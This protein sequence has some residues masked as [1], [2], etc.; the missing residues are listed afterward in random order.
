MFEYVYKNIYI[1]V[2]KIGGNFSVLGSIWYVVV[3][4][5]LFV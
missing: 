1:F 4:Y 5:N 2:R 3:F